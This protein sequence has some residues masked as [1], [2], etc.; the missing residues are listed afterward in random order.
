MHSQYSFHS[1]DEPREAKCTSEFDLARC[2]NI[3]ELSRI[4][5]NEF[6]ARER[7]IRGSLFDRRL[8]EISRNLDE[9]RMLLSG[10]E[11]GDSISLKQVEYSLHAFMDDILSSGQSMNDGIYHVGHRYA[12]LARYVRIPHSWE[13]GDP[14]DFE[15]GG[16]KYRVVPPSASR[17]G[18]LME[19]NPAM[20]T[21]GVVNSK[22]TK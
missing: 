22:A 19:F 6:I 18:E 21:L 9:I 20:M 17:A 5:E 13:R 10:C 3:A 2:D 8:K 15:I 16:M 4:S 11:H 1:A 12:P 14:V 7:I